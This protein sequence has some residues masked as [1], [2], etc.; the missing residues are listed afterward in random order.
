MITVPPAAMSGA[1]VVYSDSST[2][3]IEANE[4]HSNSAGYGGV[5]QSYGSTITIEASEFNNNSGTIGGG[6]L[7]S[8]NDITL[9]GGS[10]FT[11]KF[12]TNRS[13][14]LCRQF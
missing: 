8:I 1:G 13:S 11:K 9:K 7:Y 12:F 3:T 6:V 5:L 10:N 14:Y 4:F 2:I